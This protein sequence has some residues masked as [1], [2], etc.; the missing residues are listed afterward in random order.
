MDS[1]RRGGGNLITK[2]RR[3]GSEKRD[4]MLSAAP[5]DL[6]LE[7]PSQMVSNVTTCRILRGEANLPAGSPICSINHSDN[8]LHPRKVPPGEPCANIARRRDVVSHR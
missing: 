1:G 7:I 3:V 2:G 4:K 6:R 8:A 5:M